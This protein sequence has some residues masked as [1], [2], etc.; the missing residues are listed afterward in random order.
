MRTAVSGRVSAKAVGGRDAGVEGKGAPEVVAVLGDQQ[1]DLG[2]GGRSASAVYVHRCAVQDA[3][4]VFVG[5]GDGDDPV[6]G[7]QALVDGV[8]AREMR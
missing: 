3:A 1:G 7:E 4:Q 5:D 8:S 6:V 2:G